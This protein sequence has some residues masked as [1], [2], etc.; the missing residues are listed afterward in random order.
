MFEDQPMP[1]VLNVYQTNAEGIFIGCVQADPSPL[2]Q[3]VWLVPAGCVETAPPKFA[4]GQQAR[5]AQGTWHIE[6]IAP[7][8]PVL[9]I[10][11]ASPPTLTREAFCVAMIGVGIFTPQ[12]ATEAALGAWPPKFEPA[13]AGKEL[14]EVLTIKNL[15]RDT[16]SVT[17]DAP[18]FLDLLAFYAAARAL[19]PQNAQALGDRIFEHAQTIPV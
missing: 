18:L 4:Q 13:L 15:W 6:D 9:A 12:E 2:E 17:R 14:I 5:W 8:S 3:G 16:K 1:R 19:S 7:S 11:A 10:A